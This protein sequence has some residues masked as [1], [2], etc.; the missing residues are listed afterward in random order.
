MDGPGYNDDLDNDFISEEWQFMSNTDKDEDDSDF[1]DAGQ[2][3]NFFI[4][5]EDT[6]D[7]DSDYDLWETDEDGEFV[8]VSDDDDFEDGF[9]S[10]DDEEDDLYDD[11]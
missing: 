1:E 10:D 4:D 6:E 2:P 7:D 11:E 9:I 5:D 8:E 3:V